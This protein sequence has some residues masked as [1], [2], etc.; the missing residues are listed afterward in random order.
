MNMLFELAMMFAKLSA[1]AFGGGYV[2]IP[3]LI[4]QSEARH[5]ATATELTNVIALAGMTPG[6]VAVNAAVAYGYHIAGV[7]GAATSFL[8]I[9]VPCALIVILAASFFFKIYKHPV[10]KGAL[11]GLRPTITGIIIYAAVSIAL[12][13]GIIAF[14]TSTMIGSGFNFSALGINLFEI[15][16]VVIAVIAFLMLVKTKTHP[17]FI[18]IGSGI[19]GAVIF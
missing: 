12:K 17:V 15:K 9:A 10:V 16:S 18:I 1:F 4:Q 11:Y 7:A 8:G 6:P 5:W 13:N 2:M 3:S 19:L 14:T